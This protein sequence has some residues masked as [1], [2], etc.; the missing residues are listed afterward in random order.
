VLSNQ[1]LANLD[2]RDAPNLSRTIWANT[3]VKLSFGLVDSRER[4]DWVG[5][6]GES[7][8]YLSSYQWGL[9]GEGRST[10]SVSQQPVVHPRLNPNAFCA[11]N[12][13]PGSALL[14]V[15]GDAGL[16]SFSSVPHQIWCPYPMTLAE[17]QRRST[18]PW[19]SAPTHQLQGGQLERTVVNERAPHEVEQTAS[20]KYAAL[21]DLFRDLARRTGPGRKAPLGV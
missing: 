17:Y 9:D 6:S 16:C 3:R 5:L 10:Q 18:T 7:L 19:P 15:R 12:N 20:E 21:E 11:V 4:E 1:S 14:Y 13:A 2:T 8:G